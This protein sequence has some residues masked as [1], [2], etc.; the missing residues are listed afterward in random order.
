MFMY[1]KKRNPREHC[2]AKRTGKVML[3]LLLCTVMCGTLCLGVGADV[4]L[5][6]VPM[7]SNPL[8][9]RR[10]SSNLSIS[11]GQADLSLPCNA[12]L[13]APLDSGRTPLSFSIPDGLYPEA[14]VGVSTSAKAHLLLEASSGVV[15]A[16]KNATARL[17]MAS[18]TKIMTALIAIESLPLDT[19][20]EIPT[21]AIGVEGSSIYL[22]EGEVLTLSDLL[23]A[24]LL[25]SANDAAAA[26][27]ITVGGDIAGFAEMMNHRATTLGLTD[28]H[29]VNPHGLDDDQHYTTAYDLALITK[30]ALDNPTFRK[31]VSTQK[32]TIPLHGNQGVRLLINHNKLL[33]M[34]DGCIGVKTGFTKKTG[35][36]LVSAAER[37]GVTLIAVTLGCPDDWRD[38]TALL[39]YG[40]SVCES[41][42]L[43]APSDFIAPLWTVSGQKEYV[44]VENSS[45]L[46]M[47]LPRRRGDI[48]CVVELPRFAFAP[49]TRGQTVGRL[50]WVMTLNGQ[51]VELGEVALVTTYDVPE[52]KYKVSLWERF[53]SLFD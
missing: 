3:C 37:D 40:F 6:R 33:H 27:A 14:T 36:C 4:P 20:I 24:L 22:C 43:I 11:L 16:Q 48:H 39:D 15:L 23:Y 25:E 12:L 32:A 2:G 5:S 26:I 30:A 8:E 35:R 41:V 53:L 9:W 44:M 29:F 19:V 1:S 13:G 21:A 47:T 7:A 28:T 52:I 46:C 34:Y 42:T 38:H 31:I 50:V 10:L 45:G 18:T 17:P 51:T 49:L